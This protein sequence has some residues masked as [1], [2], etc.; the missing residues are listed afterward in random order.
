VES[1][2]NANHYQAVFNFRFGECPHITGWLLLT[3]G[4]LPI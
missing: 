2:H 4:R 1:G 3:E